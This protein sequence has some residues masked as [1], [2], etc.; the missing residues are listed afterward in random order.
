MKISFVLLVS[1]ATIALTSGHGGGYNGIKSNHFG[2]GNGH[3]GNVKSGHFHGHKKDNE[4]YVEQ[5]ITLDQ[6]PELVKKTH[7]RKADHTLLQRQKQILHLLLHLKQKSLIPEHIE[8]SRSFSPLAEGH[9]NLYLK[10]DVVEK[11][12]ELWEYTPLA[13]GAIF[14]I[15]NR[16]HLKQAIALS[17]LLYFA[18]DYD[19]FYKT[20]VWARMN[21][22]EGLFT[23]C[24]YVAVVHRSDAKGIMLPPIHEVS[25]HL[26]F[27]A[28]VIEKAQYYK[29]V[30]ESPK[31][32]REEKGFNGYTIDSDYS[33]HHLNLN[34]EQ[35]ALAYYLED[36]GV[37]SFLF[38]LHINFPFWMNSTEFGWSR[39]TRGALYYLFQQN[40][41]ARYQ[42]ERTALGFDEIEF[43]S[44]DLPVKTS[45]HSNLVYPNAVPF[46][47]RPKFAKL[48]E[49]FFNY[50]QSG[51]KSSLPGYSYTFVNDFERRI[52]EAIEAGAIWSESEGRMVE[53]GSEQ[54]FNV[55][56]NIIEG[57]HDSPNHQYYGSI[58]FFARHLLGYST[59]QLDQNEILPSALEHFETSLRDPVF[60]VLVKKLV[61]IPYQRFLQQV[62]P[63]T[64]QGLLFP[65]VEITKAEVDDLITYNETF[66]SD[67]VNSVFYS[68]KESY[69]DFQVRV[70]QPRLNHA[71][72][73]F[74]IHV[75]SDKPQKVSVKVFLGPKYDREGRPVKISDSHLDFYQ[76]DNFVA[77]LQVG[78]NV[79]SRK[80]EDNLFFSPDK[81]SYLDLYQNTVAALKGV[82]D[83]NI[84]LRQ[85]W[86][87]FP[88]RFMLPRGSV[89]GTPYQLFFAVYPYS[90]DVNQYTHNLNAI[91]L[92][93][94][95]WGFPLDRSI[96]FDKLWNEIPN[97]R[98]EEVKVYFKE[99]R[100][101]EK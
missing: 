58:W 39:F 41:L 26:F 1:F 64:K 85:N 45:Y 30:H 3:G 2:L 38:Y 82:K 69:G 28:D 7:I 91:L 72:F 90:K 56:G 51:W 4:R 101:L 18:K 97:F 76:F 25:P 94:Y 15:F 23:Y 44:W 43:L 10:D 100:F 95:P 88:Q 35:T 31:Q 8:I 13:K 59:Q 24:L 65:G 49:Y 81:V 53:M 77:N 52:V 96:K 98:F 80:S 68:P 36:V 11:F 79:I 16:N 66:Y 33:H 62:P 6:I 19:V 47:N 70:G 34:R 21:V 71:P 61:M 83:F 78:E 74:K 57:N 40:I 32:H 50:G 73:E 84:D 22:N 46:P 87:G 54:F 14:S 75:K 12:R 48:H 37:N 63:Y 55:L 5:D 60:Y 42:L 27:S 93:T 17:K 92:D 20:A 67:L 89:C 9:E 29:Q 99:D 86:Y